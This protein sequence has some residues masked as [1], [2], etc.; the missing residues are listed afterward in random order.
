MWGPWFQPQHQHF[1]SVANLTRLLTDRGF[2]VVGTE[3]GPAHQPVDLAFA[4]MLFTNRIAGAPTKPWTAPAPWYARLR[5]AA[6]F[7]ALAPVMVGALF[8]DRAIAPLVTARDGGA[9]TYRLLARKD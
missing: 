9:N 2:T 1:V 7:T 4:L 8:L 5:R 3:R 6:C